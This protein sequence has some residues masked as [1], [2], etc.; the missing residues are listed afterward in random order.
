MMGYGIKLAYDEDDAVKLEN[1]YMKL[2]LGKDY[3]L[4][5]GQFKPRFLREDRISSRY[6]QAVDRSAVRM[7]YSLGYVQGLSLTGSYKSWGWALAAHDGRGKTLNDD[8]ITSFATCF[9]VE[10]FMAGRKSEF[11]DYAAWSDQSPG[12]M[13][14][15]GVDHEDVLPGG[16]VEEFTTW[17]TDVSLKIHPFNVF[18]AIIGRHAQISGDPDPNQLGFVIQAGSF[19]VPDYLDLFARWERFSHDGYSEIGNDNNQKYK[20]R[21]NQIN[22]YV[23]GLNYYFARHDAK[24]SADVEWVPA[25]LYR[26]ESNLGLIKSDND[27]EQIVYRVQLQFLL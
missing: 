10:W 26:K 15:A 21:Y 6:Q 25:G 27:V 23:A 11:K 3:R 18:A 22:L 20:S 7:N 12:L 4:Y 13:V 17:T 5:L 9:R 1:F 24:L 2:R 16:N 14:G 19:V 8:D